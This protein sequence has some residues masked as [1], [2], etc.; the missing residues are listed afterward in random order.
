[1]DFFVVIRCPRTGEEV[2]T[3]VVA[4]ITN[5]DRLPTGPTELKC[6]ACGETHKWY[7]GDALLTHS[8]SGLDNWRPGWNGHDLAIP[9]ARATEPRSTPARHATR[10]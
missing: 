1:M 7:R 2:P 10:G 3:G 8:L 9:Q 4:D 6:V 5:L